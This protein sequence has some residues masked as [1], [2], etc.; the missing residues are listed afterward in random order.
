MWPFISKKR[1]RK[2]LLRAFASHVSPEILKSLTADRPAGP[3]VLTRGEIFYVVCQVRD[4]V[5][6]DVAP[7]LSRAATIGR[8]HGSTIDFM[9]SAVMIL[10]GVPRMIDP[11]TMTIEHCAAVAA[12]LLQ[13]LGSHA[14]V[15]YGRAEGLHGAIGSPQRQHYG[16]VIPNFNRI[17]ERLCTL[18]Y[19]QSVQI[20]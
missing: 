19:G 3:T 17:L 16:T 2:E 8:E 15:A 6:D 9:P 12:A 10:F 20:E 14:R 1:Q 18:D 7:L 13:D 4:D 11:D 5:L